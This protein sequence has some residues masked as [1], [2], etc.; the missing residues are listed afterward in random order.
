M[1][2]GELRMELHHARG[3]TDDAAIAW[4]P[5]RGILCCGDFFIWASPNAA[6]GIYAWAVAES[7]AALDD[8]TRTTEL[9][10][11]TAGRTQ[12]AL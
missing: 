12:W 10:S 11:M 1:N 2:I 7:R 6:K 8:T 5:D 3:E 4:I 9:R